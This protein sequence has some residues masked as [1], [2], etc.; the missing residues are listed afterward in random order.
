MCAQAGDISLF[1]SSSVC[2]CAVTPRRHSYIVLCLLQPWLHSCNAKARGTTPPTPPPAYSRAAPRRS[3][4]AV[5]ATTAGMVGIPSVR[6]RS[7]GRDRRGPRCASSYE[8]EAK[9]EACSPSGRARLALIGSK[10]DQA[11]GRPLR[12][13]RGPRCR[14]S[15]RAGHLLPGRHGRRPR[16]PGLSAR[17]R[18]HRDEEHASPL[19]AWGDGAGQGMD[20]DGRWPFALGQGGA[21]GTRRRVYVEACASRASRCRAMRTPPSLVCFCEATA[22]GSG[23]ATDAARDH[24]RGARTAPTTGRACPSRTALLL[25]Q[26]V[27]RYGGNGRRTYRWRCGSTRCGASRG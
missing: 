15:L 13:R 27:L 8:C 12:R 5:A 25:L 26:C 1:E 9:G 18:G 24:G 21:Q 10:D 19:R 6:G 17:P 14:R 4:R 3:R 7:A 23:L 22:R 11:E 16:R 2:V 20:E